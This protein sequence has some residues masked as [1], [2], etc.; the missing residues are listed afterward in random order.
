MYQTC[1]K[2]SSVQIHLWAC[3]S[4]SLYKHVP[5]F[6]FFIYN[7]MDVCSIMCIHPPCRMLELESK[8][9]HVY[10]CV[11]AHVYIMHPIMVIHADIVSWPSALCAMSN[12]QMP[13]PACN[14]LLSGRKRWWFG[15]REKQADW[16]VE[17]ERERTEMGLIKRNWRNHWQCA[18]MGLSL[19]WAKTRRD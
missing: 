12:T 1:S 10:M 8:G 7:F 14:L 5:V 9:V 19:D 16:E 18:K 15:G 3:R 13:C 17:R 6:V 4:S 2:L 11:C